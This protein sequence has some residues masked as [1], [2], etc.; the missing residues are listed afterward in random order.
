VRRVGIEQ[1][2]RQLSRHL[3]AVERGAEIEITDRGRPIARLIPATASTGVRLQPAE[4]PV[5]AL[6]KKR[7]RPARW[8]IDSLTLL[9]ED[10]RCR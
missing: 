5:A 9:L 7:F 2:R 10:R 8:P 4:K 6:L 1:L 3:R